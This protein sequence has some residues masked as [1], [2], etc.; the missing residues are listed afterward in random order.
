MFISLLS[1]YRFLNK[2]DMYKLLCFLFLS[3]LVISCNKSSVSQT[4]YETLDGEK[5]FVN[6]H[7]SSIIEEVFL[8]DSSKVPATTPQSTS[9]YTFNKNAQLIELLH[10]TAGNVLEIR[11]EYVY[12]ND[13]LTEELHYN[14]QNELDRKIIYNYDETNKPSYYWVFEKEDLILTCY[15][16]Y[17][18]ED[19]NTTLLLRFVD[20]NNDTVSTYAQ[21]LNPKNQ[22]L[23]T[24][25]LELNLKTEYHYNSDGLLIQSIDNTESNYVEPLVFDY[26]YQFDKHNNWIE[27]YVSIDGEPTYL[28]KRTIDYRK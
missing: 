5:E 26:Q 9:N 7:A 8:L 18:V 17:G 24:N 15:Y 23:Y 10:Y 2:M 13:R 19:N 1:L 11:I 25:I 12:T 21:L 22:L 6:G 28:V 16:T 20:N 14:A 3:T 27:K 4:M